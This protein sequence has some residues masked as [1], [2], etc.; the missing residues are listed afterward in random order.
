MTL[1]VIGPGFGRTGTNSLRL[2]LEQIGFG[3]CHH[4]FEVRDNSELLAD[5]EALAE[6]KM[7]DW[8]QVFAGYR[9]QVDW[10]GAHYWRQLIRAFPDANVILTVRDP[11]DWIDSVHATI[12]PF[13]E[14]RGQHDSA[15]MNAIAEMC[16][17]S[18]IK[19]TFDDRLGDRDHAKKIFERHVA[20][21]QTIV[22]KDRLLTFDVR[23]GWDPL[24]AFLQVKVP[25]TPFPMTNSSK[26]FIEK[27]DSTS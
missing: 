22:A 12:H 26:E 17:K 27:V 25:D 11:N 7:R 6:G 21:V 10:P 5:W 23:Q 8:N 19:G 9:S 13:I 4:M 24:C 16:H 20:E 14:A 1:E 15:H 2:A 18:I 3:K